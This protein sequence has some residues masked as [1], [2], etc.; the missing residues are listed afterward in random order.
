MHKTAKTMIVAT[1]AITLA[2]P[3][4]A[5]PKA[6]VLG[7]I[8]SPAEGMNGYRIEE[9]SGLAWDADE[10][11]LYAVSDRGVLHHFR[12]HLDGN[13]IA[14]MEVIYS[15]A[16]TGADGTELTVNDAEDVA[17][18]NGDNGRES[19]SEL[20]IALEDGPAVA[21]FT[22]Q[23]KRLADVGLPAPLSDKAQ[24]A[25]KNRR[26]E[27]VAFDT[28]YGMVTAP[29]TALLGRP[30]DQHTLYATGGEKWT[31]KAFQPEHSNLKA[32]EIM[33]DGNALVLERTREK[34][35]APFVGRLRYVDLAGCGERRTCS[36]TDYMP[37]PASGL[38]NNFE[39][40]TRLFDNL[41]LLVTDKTVK[42]GEP[43]SFTLLA[44]QPMA[45]KLYQN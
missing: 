5:A 19:D 23:G 17:V 30:E 10:K 16:L 42:D 29:E 2:G 24:Y 37:E 36:V 6:T 38:A 15:A 43:T 3:A 21:R 35:G 34:K 32:I 33:P 14:R 18:I 41:L 4:L 20:L 27:S 45:G 13:R 12:I 22:P 26:L 25:K 9:L 31:F 40:M 28:R 44:L 1:V 7:H 11:L 39:G 8:D